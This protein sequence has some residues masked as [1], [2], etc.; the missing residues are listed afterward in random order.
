MDNDI[1]K[2]QLEEGVSPKLVSLAQHIEAWFDQYTEEDFKNGKG[3]SAVLFA[4]D[5]DVENSRLFYSLYDKDNPQGDIITAID[6]GIAGF[7]KNEN[8]NNSHDTK[9]VFESMAQFMALIFAKFPHIYD[10][11]QRY[12]EK[13][14][15]AMK[16]NIEEGKNGI[17]V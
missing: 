2:L 12:V 1:N 6:H 16:D 13:Y 7:L 11:F 4:H 14:Q 3:V 10:S 15:Q 9:L 8:S 5:K 17:I